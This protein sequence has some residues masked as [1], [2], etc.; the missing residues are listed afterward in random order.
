M[1][2]PIP[3][4]QRPLCF[5]VVPPG[6]EDV[7]MSELRAF[8]FVHVQGEVGGVSF[9]GDPLRANRVLSCA[10]RILYRVGRFPAPSFPAFER[11]FKA[12]DL[13]RF[14][15]LTPQASTRKSK[16]YHTGAIEERVARWC[17]SGP[18]TVLIRLNKDKCT[19]SIDTSGER[20]HRRGW[21]LENG[22]A[23][24]R[25]TLAARRAGPA[26]ARRSSLR[27]HVWFRNISDRSCRAR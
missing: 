1:S 22:P 25:E 21:R 15:G 7:M 17:P 14:G 24:M 20:L 16:L 2:A 10:T 19:V 23:P 18:T 6:F 11:G 9:R 8:G 3:T 27:S 4:S 26:I 13:S 5:A 12:L